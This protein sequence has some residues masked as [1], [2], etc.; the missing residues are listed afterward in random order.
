MRTELSWLRIL[1]SQEVYL[2]R[3]AATTTAS[4]PHVWWGKCLGITQQRDGILVI[5]SL[6]VQPV[7]SYLG[8]GAARWF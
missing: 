3:T 7:S 4:S 2:V 6:F 8:G 5:G 1:S